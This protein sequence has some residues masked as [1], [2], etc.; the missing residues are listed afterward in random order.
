MAIDNPILSPLPGYV[1]VIDADGNHIYKPTAETVRKM[2]DATVQNRTNQNTQEMLSALLN[3]KTPG[4]AQAA[5]LSHAMQLFA[6]TIEDEPTMMSIASVYPEYRVN[7]AY[8]LKDI[9]R[10]GV[11]SVGDPQLYQV[12]QAHISS[13]EFPPETSAS[14]YKKVGVMEDGTPLWIQPLGATDAYMLGDIVLH[15]DQKWKSDIG[16][17]VWEPGVY[18]WSE[19]TGEVDPEPSDEIPDFVQPGGSEDAYNIGDR[20]RFT[21]GKVY[22]SLIDGNVWSPTDYPDGWKLIEE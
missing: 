2:R 1:E 3:T 19:Y 13:E 11:N 12:L 18:G 5:E 14:L 10:H 17:N 21:D 9:F 4:P 22:E 16:N 20:V 6:C 8:K 15:N 7:V